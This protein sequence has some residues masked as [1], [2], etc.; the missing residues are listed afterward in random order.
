MDTTSKTSKAS[1]TKKGNSTRKTSQEKQQTYDAD[2]E[3]ALALSQSEADL[4]ASAPLS[5]DIKYQEHLLH[6]K[7]QADA[8]EEYARQLAA[9]FEAQDADADAGTSASASASAVIPDEMHNANAYGSVDIDTVDI[10]TVLDEIDR[11]EAQAQLKATGH[12]YNGKTNINRI[13]ADEDEEEARIREKVRRAQE[14]NEWRAERA[15]QDAEYAAM[16]EYDRT[17]ELSKQNATED[18][19]LI[20]PAKLAETELATATASA[21]A[22]ASTPTPESESTHESEPEPTPL[23]KEELR[24]AR[25]AFFTSVPANPQTKATQ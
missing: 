23:T 15:R 4:G 8:D 25:L 21:P 2:A 10:D 6:L 12:A 9:E 11:V 22:H 7:H 13:L 20:S 18:S 1:I 5:E 16:E 3:L 14:L 19:H 17:R 24:K